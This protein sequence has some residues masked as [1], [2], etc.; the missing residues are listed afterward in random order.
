MA[1]TSV[2]AMWHA[3]LETLG[4]APAATSRVLSSWHFCDHEADANECVTLVLRGIKRATSPSL[5]WFDHT[6]TPLPQ[7]GD[8]HVVTNWDGEAQCVIRTERVGI[9]PFNEV[10]SDYALIEGE[11]DGSL[12]Y[13]RRVH[14]EYYLREL[15]GSPYVPSGDMP[16]VCEQFTVVYAVP[17][18]RAQ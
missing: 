17:A 5:W 12:E 10:S 8:L 1:N 2:H 6:A 15:D 9:V 13:W 14:W 3:Y 18:T 4:D 11:G 7:V 16:I